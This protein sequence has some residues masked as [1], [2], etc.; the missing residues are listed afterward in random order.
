MRF[1]HFSFVTLLSQP[2]NYK[3]TLKPFFEKTFN[4]TLF[5]CL[6]VFLSFTTLAQ[7]KNDKI[8][9]R[10]HPATSSIKIDGIP[11]ERA[12]AEAQLATDFY[13]VLPMDTSKA[14]VKTEV[15][16]TYD[17]KNLYIL[18]INYDYA[19]GPY[20]V[21]SLKR[22]FAFGKNDNDLL[23]ID[24]FDD[25]TN[26]FTFGANAHGAQWDGLLYN[27]SAANLSWENKWTSEVKYDDDKWIWEAAIPFKTLRYKKGITRW[28]VNFSRLDLKTTEKS[29]W[30]P[31]PRQFPTA[32]LAYCAS[33]VWDQ[34]PPQAGSNISIIPYA[35]GGISANQEAKTPTKLR[36][37]IGFDAKIGLTSSLN[38]DLTVNPDFSQV[39]VDQQQTNLDRFE[40][41]FPEKRQFFLENGDLFSNFGYQTIRPFF[42]RRIGLNAPI[43]FGA[44]LSGKLNKDWRIGFMDMQ[45]G[46]NEVGVPAQNFGVIALQRRMFARSNIAIML[47]N[48]ETLNYGGLSDSLIRLNSLSQ[49][50]RNIGIEYNLASKNND[51]TGKF[52][53][54]N[55]FG[56]NTK[57]NDA[58]FAGNILYTNKKW[59]AGV[60]VEQVGQTYSA[61]VGYVPRINYSKLN[62]QVAYLFFPKAG[63][64][65]LSHG[66]LAMLTHYLTKDFSQETENEKFIA[67]KVN[68][69]KTNTLMV[70]AA[71]NYVKLLNRF[72]PTNYAGAYLPI[73]SEHRWNSAGFDYTSKPQALLTYLVS[74]RYGGYYANG[75]RL[76]LNGEIGYRFQPF[77]AITMSA[78]YNRL[79]FKED[80][81]LPKELI[82]KQY[83][84]WLLGPKIDVTFTN[85][86]FLTNFVQFNNQN[87][88]FNINTRLQWRYSPASDLFLVYTDNYFS[89]TFNVR[90]RSLVVKFTYWWNV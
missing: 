61:E 25:Q 39:E 90:N 80:P 1:L 7:K 78:N 87:N 21:E 45:T 60:Q 84:L 46:K 8:E 88:N 17:D 86:L 69:R 57:N 70:W 32:S 44:R 67:Y 2:Y 33:L 71:H 11:D 82:N 50:N 24:T 58:V 83:N 35:L 4:L 76:R 18:F 38:L 79:A 54:L 74:T 14:F 5:L 59:V 29:A 75:T 63:G 85:K 36:G 49:F 55:S 40:L 48:K 42:S 6:F 19:P 73:G 64:T 77:V 27:G 15:K 72:D 53:Y 62:P 37:D 34:P 10:I 56:P 9:Y 81:I 13:Q 3:K 22:D 52:L 51:W 23:F 12:W 47:V 89:D 43:H 20:M 16:M 68:F 31:V 41:L 30:A 66:P 65:V 26:G 28:G